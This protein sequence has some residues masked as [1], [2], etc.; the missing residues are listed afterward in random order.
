MG[1]SPTSVVNFLPN[2]LQYPN[3][4]KATDDVEN[5]VEWIGVSFQ[6]QSKLQYFNNEPKSYA[7]GKDKPEFGL[8]SGDLIIKPHRKAPAA[9]QGYMPKFVEAPYPAFS[10]KVGGHKGKQQHQE[11]K[12]YNT[13]GQQVLIVR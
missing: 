3:C 4:S 5:K 7:A 10:Q 13:E 1:V 9:K 2:F 12:A 8:W 11:R 6:W